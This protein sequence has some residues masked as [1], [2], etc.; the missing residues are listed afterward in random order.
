VKNRG[1]KIGL[2]STI[3]LTDVNGS[4]KGRRKEEEEKMR[5]GRDRNP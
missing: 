1:S 5:K 3:F 2:S 4:R